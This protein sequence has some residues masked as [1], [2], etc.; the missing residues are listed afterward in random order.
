[1]SQLEMVFA[2]RDAA[3]DRV[4]RNAD[5]QDV[6][7][8]DQAIRTVAARGVSFSANDVRPLLPPLRS[9]NLVGARFLALKGA[10]EIRRVTGQ[11]VPSTEPST[12]GHVIALWVAA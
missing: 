4:N 3:L 12:H 6:S 8:V 11:Y 10:G 7:V 9:N 5:D 2:A 1:M